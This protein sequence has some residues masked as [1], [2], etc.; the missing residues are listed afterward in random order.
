M[1]VSYLYYGHKEAEIIGIYLLVSFRV[2]LTQGDEGVM[3]ETKP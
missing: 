2:N 1:Q 3:G